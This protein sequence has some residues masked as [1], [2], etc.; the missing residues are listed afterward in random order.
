ML[1][2]HIFAFSRSQLSCVRFTFP[3]Y[4]LLV[5][6]G[7]IFPA[8]AFGASVIV[9]GDIYNLAK[10]ISYILSALVFC[11]AV[12]ATVIGHHPLAFM[13]FASAVGLYFVFHLVNKLFLSPSNDGALIFTKD[14]GSDIQ[15]GMYFL[16]F[17]LLAALISFVIARAFRST[18]SSVGSIDGSVSTSSAET[19]TVDTVADLE[20]DDEPLSDSLS[21][22]HIKRKIIKD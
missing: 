13:S 19:N 16:L 5:L 15:P 14:A 8:H 3:A 17:F 20:S 22:S 10:F 18:G 1:S 4:V 2:R 6:V 21:N 12:Y 7:L 9:I 11:I